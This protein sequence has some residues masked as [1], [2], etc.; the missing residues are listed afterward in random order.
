MAHCSFRGRPTTVDVLIDTL[1]NHNCSSTSPSE[2]A[3]AVAPAGGAQANPSRG[4]TRTPRDSLRGEGWWLWRRQ[5]QG[6]RPTACR[7]WRRGGKGRREQRAVEREL[8][9]ELRARVPTGRGKETLPLGGTLSAKHPLSPAGLRQ[10]SRN[11]AEE[12]LPR[13]CLRAGGPAGL[14]EERGAEEAA[15]ALPRG[16]RWSV[17]SHR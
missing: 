12:R 1:L 4:R 13:S 5:G 16:C 7:L 9:E 14:K 6:E 11:E 10:M 15:E 3:R 2:L 17:S 8:G